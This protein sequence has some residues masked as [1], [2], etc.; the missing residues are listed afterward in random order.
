M[1]HVLQWHITHKC[2]LRCTHCYQNEYCSDITWT[3]MENIFYQYLDFIK[4]FNYIGHINFT[5]GEPFVNEHIWDLLDLCENNKITFGVLTNGTLLTKEMI[6]RL[7]KYTK[8][9][10]IQV[11]ID[12][13]KPTH[14][15][16]RGEGTFDKTFKALKMLRKAKIQTMVAF[17]CHKQN[18]LELS[19]VIKLVRKHKIDRFWT[20]RFIPI[21]ENKDFD[22]SMILS[23]EEYRLV[24]KLLTKERVKK[25]KTVIHTNR[26]LQFSEGCGEIYQCSAGDTLLAILADGTLLPCRRLPIEVGNVLEKYILELYNSSELIADLRKKEIPEKCNKCYHASFCR[27]GA[28]CLSYA[29]HGDYNRRDENCYLQK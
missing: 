11:S 20:D 23:T 16:I 28:K 1:K 3:Q 29:L 27:G 19:N 12:G 18:Y 5:G 25:S 7:S 2:N 13:T 10:F 14:D 15:S 17:T 4:H 22:R 24:I 6:L 26:A 8:L 21:D 9:S